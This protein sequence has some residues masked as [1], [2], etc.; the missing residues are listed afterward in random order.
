LAVLVL[1]EFQNHFCEPAQSGWVE[2][3]LQF[4]EKVADW[5]GRRNKCRQIASSALNF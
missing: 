1:G 4:G 5:G 3:H 2:Q